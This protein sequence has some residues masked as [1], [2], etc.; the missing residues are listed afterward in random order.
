MTVTSTS[1]RVRLPS[2]LAVVQVV[3]ACRYGAL[4][5]LNGVLGAWGKREL[6]AWLRGTYEPI[7]RFAAGEGVMLDDAPASQRVVSPHAAERVMRDAREEVVAH[8]AELA[9]PE[10][11]LAFAFDAIGSLAARCEDE[12]GEVGWIP[13]GR[14]RMRLAERAL[15]LVAADYLTRSEDY[16][17]R[18]AICSRCGIVAF[19]AAARSRGLCRLHA[20][21]GIRFR[22]SVPPA[23]K[24]AG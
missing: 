9:N 18:I 1:S 3:D 20:A 8:L 22:S 4:G 16:E 17:E 15:S 14:P 19:D 11:A 6:G 23:S 24:A 12:A 21:S 13:I 2:G 10:Q 7:A 5:F